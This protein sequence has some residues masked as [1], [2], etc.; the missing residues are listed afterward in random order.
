MGSC[1]HTPTPQQSWFT[2]VDWILWGSIAAL[3]A[4]MLCNAY[5]FGPGT[6]TTF[7][8]VANQFIQSLWGSAIVAVITIGLMNFIPPSW[9]QR[10]L[11]QG[12]SWNGLLRAMLA[13]LTLDLCSHGVLMVG[14]KLYRQGASLGQLFTFLITSPWNS[15]SMMLILATLVGWGWVAIF[16]ALS[17]TVGVL[18]GAMV[19]T[20]VSKGILPNNPYPAIT[21][22]L[23]EQ[24][25]TQPA[26]AITQLTDWPKALWHGLQESTMVLRWLLF[27]IVLAS[28]IQAW[29]PTDA[30]AAWFGPTWL[31]LGLTLVAATL[32]EVCSEGST[33]L[34]AD[35]IT[36]AAAP[37]NAFTFLMAGAATDVTEVMV[38]KDLHN[39]RN[40]GWWV[41]LALPLLTVPQVLLLG[42]LLNQWS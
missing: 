2:Q 25:I 41:A 38:L 12:Q 22:G 39:A 17:A 32:I 4:G 42:W 7:G 27:G 37:G 40:K 21:D 24:A 8:H 23:S 36:R 3:A 29:V 5:Q 18:T 30:F 14:T 33:P 9:M 13:G 26:Y 34:A 19:N 28:A 16:V 20:L 6:V 11:G 1:C 15:L 35:L 10:L 31:G